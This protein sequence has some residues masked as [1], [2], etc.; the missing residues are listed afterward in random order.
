[1]GCACNPFS[2]SPQP[3]NT[4]ASAT[5]ASPLF[6]ASFNPHQPPRNK[7]FCLHLYSAPLH[8]PKPL[9]NP[10]FPLPEI[11][12]SL[13]HGN[14]NN[15]SGDGGGGGHGGSGD[16]N[17][18]N[19]FKFD[20][21]PL[22]LCLF[23]RN[24][25]NQE[26]IFVINNQI[27]RPLFS[28]L[29]AAAASISCYF[30]FASLA[31]AKTAE[32]EKHEEE[33]AMVCEIKGG[34][35]IGVVPDYEKDEFIVPKTTWSSWRWWWEKGSEEKIKISM[36]D[37]WAQCRDLAMNL[38]LPE[39]FPESVTSDYLEYSLWR[40]VQGVAAQISGVLATQVKLHFLHFCYLYNF[41]RACCCCY[42][43][44]CCV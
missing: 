18:W 39:G 2:P 32:K 3:L 12:S 44:V 9:Q 27:S 34:K 29:I 13:Y 31:D 41:F 30:S 11:F 8:P 6:S 1:M 15:N 23:T 24:L 20:K 37:L 21:N 17:D 33:E 14:N 40:G 42:S 19:S 36:G 35:K 5:K 4:A 25:A 7:P 28:I 16:N 43:C 22:F 10:T 26:D 38:M